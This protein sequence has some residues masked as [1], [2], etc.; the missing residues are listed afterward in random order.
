MTDNNATP[1]HG[2]GRDSGVDEHIITVE[3]TQKWRG[4]VSEKFSEKLTSDYTS[5]DGFGREITNQAVDLQFVEET[6]I[7]YECSCG[8]RFRKGRT[9][10][11]HLEGNDGE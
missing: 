1:R 8:Q 4:Q 10:R 11:E 7:T 9:A 5:T 3:S 2:D 6:K